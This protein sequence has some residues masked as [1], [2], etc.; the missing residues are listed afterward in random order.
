MA[1]PARRRFN[2]TQYK[3]DFLD[4]IK[5]NPEMAADSAKRLAARKVR[6]ENQVED[7]ETAT[8]GVVAL[9]VGITVTSA[10]GWWSGGLQA[11]RDA[12]VDDWELQGAES[13]GAA[14]ADT[15]FPWQHERGVGHPM[16]WFGF[17]PKL[18]LVPVV[19]AG[20]AG[21][22]A[23]MRKKN[24]A[25]GYVEKAMTTT[26]LMSFG[27]F[28]ASFVGEISYVGK[29]KKYARDGVD[30]VASSTNGGALAA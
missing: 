23:A 1:K 7:D 4:L 28:A 19:A 8:K 15:P 5:A 29:E 21:I 25:P 13:V 3:E 10:T 17:F 22:A 16:Y 11:K 6:A 24:Q 18:L 14:V 26:A 20:W 27:V 30:S 12:L 2:G 9:M